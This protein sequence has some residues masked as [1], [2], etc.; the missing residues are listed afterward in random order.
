MSILIPSLLLPTPPPQVQRILG[1]GSALERNP[2]LQKHI[3]QVFSLPL[4]LTAADAAKGA[5]LA[6][7]NQSADTLTHPHMHTHGLNAPL[8][9][10]SFHVST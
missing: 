1:C 10:K 9:H 8:F 7:F 3:E 6:S 4:L 2:V 5:A